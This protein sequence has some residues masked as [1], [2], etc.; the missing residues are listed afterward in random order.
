MCN[1]GNHYN[2]ESI[3]P[4]RVVFAI[5]SDN[6]LSDSD[7]FV[8]NAIPHTDM[9]SWKMKKHAPVGDDPFNNFFNC[10]KTQYGNLKMFQ[11]E[12]FSILITH[13][14]CAS[15]FLIKLALT[16]WKHEMKP[17]IAL[18]ARGA[19]ST[20]NN[21]PKQMTSWLIITLILATTLQRWG[22]GE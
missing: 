13:E 9:T 21:M 5:A 17:L 18:K 11:P 8:A 19:S 22:T 3:K 15:G 20:S 2:S 1:A 10:R 4:L 16:I 12:E 14:I 7:S 6:L